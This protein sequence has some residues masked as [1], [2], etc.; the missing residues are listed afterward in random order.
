MRRTL[1]IASVF[2]LAVLLCIGIAAQQTQPFPG[3]GTGVVP[4]TGTVNIANT[5]SVTASQAGEWKVAVSNAPDVRVVNPVVVAP[6]DFLKKGAR[7]GITWPTGNS[8][9]LVVAQVGPLGWI[10]AE[11]TGRVRWVNVA[12]ARSI[13]EMP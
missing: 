8:E 3:P 10:R 7:Y 9:T 6:P 12:T 13:E 11:E 2:T 4:V 1:T 5:P